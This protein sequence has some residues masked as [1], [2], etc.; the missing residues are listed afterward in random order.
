MVLRVLKVS[1]MPVILEISEIL[2]FS[3]DSGLCCCLE[4]L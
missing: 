1:E 3:V 2:D 4:S